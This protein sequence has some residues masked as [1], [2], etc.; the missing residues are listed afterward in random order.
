MQYIVQNGTN[1]L[2]AFCEQIHCPLEDGQTFCF[3][4]VVDQ[5]KSIWF[6]KIALFFLSFHIKRVVL[7]EGLGLD[8]SSSKDM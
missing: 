8:L 6:S 7:V 5:N 4:F 3:L 2:L 1:V